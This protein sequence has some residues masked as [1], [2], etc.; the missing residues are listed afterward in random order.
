MGISLSCGNCARVITELLRIACMYVRSRM[1]SD[2]V[3]KAT[4]TCAFQASQVWPRTTMAT[5]VCIAITMIA[6]YLRY[7]Y[8]KC[9]EKHFDYCR[10]NTDK[11]QINFAVV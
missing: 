10:E 1:C 2:A 3:L 8:F 9:I 4:S 7:A 5:M 6:R 11:Y